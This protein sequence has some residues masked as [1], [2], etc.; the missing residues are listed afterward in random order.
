[1]FFPQLAAFLLALMLLCYPLP[2]KAQAAKY[3][4]HLSY[5]GAQLTAR[6]FSGQN[7]QTAEFATAN[8]VLTNF[9]DADLRGAVFSSSNMTKA[10]LHGADMSYGM[11]DK[12]DFTGADLSEAVFVETIMLRSIFDETDITGADFSYAML[13]GTQVKELCDQASG[14]NPKTGVATRDSLG[15]R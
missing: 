9:T 8:L 13:D 12:V 5:S 4:P 3:P 6:D 2:V 10:N 11:A 7:L 15:C 14:I 1:M